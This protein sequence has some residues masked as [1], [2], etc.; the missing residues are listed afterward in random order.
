MSVQRLARIHRITQTVEKYRKK[1]KME[2]NY[3]FKKVFVEIQQNVA[4]LRR[5]RKE[6]NVST[7]LRSYVNIISKTAEFYSSK[8]RFVVR[9]SMERVEFRRY[10]ENDGGSGKWEG[11]ESEQ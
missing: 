8:E 3:I 10:D 7:Y 6:T 11:V 1:K 9:G 4:F 5:I 2:R